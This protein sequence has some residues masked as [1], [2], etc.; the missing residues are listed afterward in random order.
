MAGFRAGAARN[1]ITPELGCHICGY[2]RDRI[3]TDIHD[4]LYAKA[5]VLENDDTALA[6]VV[7]D[8]I[9]LAGDDV[10][11]AK[12]HAERLT[13]IGRDNILIS[14]THTHYGP[15][16]VGALGTPRDDRTMERAAQRIGDSVRLAQNR[17]QPAEVGVA[18]TTCPGE[19]FNRRWHMKDGT[20]QMNPGHQNPDALRTAGPADPEVLVL[21]VRS[22]NREPI[23]LLANYALH[24]VGGPCHTSI[25]ADY[26]GYFDRALQRMAGRDL[27][28]IMANGFCG[29]LNNVDASQPEPDMPHPFYQEERVANAVAAAA[30]G[31]WQGLRGFQYDSAPALR[32]GTEMMEFRRRESSADELARAR[33]LLNAGEDSWSDESVPDFKDRV[34]AREAL[35]V[36]DEPLERAIPIMAMRIGELG[37]VGLPGEIFVEYGLHIKGRSRFTNTMTIELANDFVGYCPTDKALGEG[38]YETQLAR[39]SKAAP[40]TEAAMVGA[41]LRALTRVAA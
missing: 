40:G 8:L 33:V 30:Y 24:Y 37:L 34:Y 27:V 36:A 41:A 10:A 15:A 32:A 38:S 3:A 31:A 19:T 29:D 1:C 17:L 23:A 39:T 35:Y 25:S 22:P 5:V 4:A 13:G 20:V 7:C 26:F 6:I 18:S 9:A 12:E 28:A 11:A 16:T 21:A 14:C 2:S